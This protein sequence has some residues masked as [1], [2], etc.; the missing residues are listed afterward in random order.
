MKEIQE[1]L[2]ITASLKERYKGKLDLGLLTLFFMMSS[3]VYSQE[4]TIKQTVDYADKHISADYTLK[5]EGTKLVKYWYNSADDATY[6]QGYVEISNLSKV[7][8]ESAYGMYIVKLWCINK[9]KCAKSVTRSGQFAD[10]EYLDLWTVD[11]EEA[12]L[13]AN[14]MRYL[15][16]NFKESEYAPKNDP[17]RAYS[18]NGNST[19]KTVGWWGEIDLGMSKNQVFKSIKGLNVDISL[20]TLDDNSEI[21]RAY[22]YP[23]LLFLYFKNDR[24]I[25]VDRG[26]RSP[27]AIIMIEQH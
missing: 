11:S 4:Y 19:M 26:E 15:I 2:D 9:D 1:L 17:F 16:A 20:D 14:A 18:S 7:D 3:L 21:Y 8:F 12:E 23:D 13:V 6:K 25:R 24:L 27:D 22:K 10:W 5:L